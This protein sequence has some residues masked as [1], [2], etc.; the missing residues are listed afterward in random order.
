MALEPGSGALGGSPESSGRNSPIPRQWRNQLGG[1]ELQIKDK[2]YRRYASGVEKA[3]L[4]F[5][6]ALEEWADYISF[7][8]KLLKALQTRPSSITAIPH[9][10]TVAKRLSQCLNPSLPSGVHQKALEV[11]NYIFT[12]IGKDGLSCDIPLYLPGLA[13]TLSFASLSV[14][15]PFLDLLESYFLQIDPRSLRPAMKS[16][17]LALLPGLED[18]TSEDFDRTLALVASFKK[19]LRPEDSE[20][21]SAHH[22]SSDEFFWQC[23]FLASI[24]SHSRRGGALAYLVRFLPA[25]GRSPAAQDSDTTSPT[26]MHDE[27][28]KISALVTTPEPGLLVRCFASGLADD[29]LLIQRGFLDLLVSH[30]PLNSTVL[31]SRVKPADL[32]LLVKAAVGVVTRRDM[33]LNRRLWTW[34]LGPEPVS[35]DGDATGYLSTA[36]SDQQQSF[37]SSRTTYFEDFGL[38][39]LTKALLDM[40]KSSIRGNAIE[41]ARPYRI[42]LSLM[43]R[44]E[45]GG[46]IVPEVFLP[47]IESVRQF[48]DHSPSRSEFS[49]VLRSASV[50]FDGIE[51]GLIYS[52]LVSLLAQA[53][54]PGSLTSVE[55]RDKVSLVNFII[56]NFNVREEE[57]ITIH[58][59]LTCVAALAMLEDSRAR[60]TKI[61]LADGELEQLSQ[62]VLGVV[63]SLLELVP[64]RAFPDVS[65]LAAGD[66]RNEQY[67]H[68]LSNTEILK[69]I[70]AFYVHGQGNLE[71]AAIPFN[72]V[73][74]GEV[75]LHKAASFICNEATEHDSMSDLGIRV[76]ILILILLKTPTSYTFGA[77]DLLS[78]LKGKLVQGAALH[79]SYF[80]SVVQLATQLHSTDR[81]AAEQL[82]ALVAPLVS[83]AWHYLSASDPKYHVETVRC[84]WQLQTSLTLSARDIEASLSAILVDRLLLVQQTTSSAAEAARTFGVLWSHTLQDSASDRRGS[85]TQLQ[86]CRTISRLA[87]MDHYQVM[88]AQPLFLVLDALI[89]ERTQLYMVVKSWLN[90]MIG[91]DR[92]FLLFVTKISELSFV[93]SINGHE[94]GEKAATDNVVFNEN[95]DIELCLY[96]LRSL[97]HVLRCTGEMTR[98]VLASKYLYF[99][100]GEV[101]IRAGAEDNEI[102]LQEF[103]VRVCLQCVTADVADR[104]NVEL[105]ERVSQLHR[106][107][108][109]ILHEFLSSR[110]AA[111]LTSLHLDGILV[112]RLSKSIDE[113]DPYVQVLLLDVI[114]DVLKIHDMAPVE[115]ST[116]PTLEKSPPSFD[117]SRP[118]R[119]S[120]SMSESRPIAPPMPPQLLKCLQAGLS[121][122]SSHAVLDSWV[123][124]LS[125]CLPLYSQSIFQVLIP[126]V[127]TLCRQVGQVFTSLRNTFKAEQQRQSPN[128]SAPEA[129]L[130]YLLNGLEQVLALAH[131]QLLAAESRAQTVKGPEQPQSLFGSMVSG[132]FQS[133]GPQARSATANDR[134]TVHLAFQDAMRI[135]FRIWSWG[136]GEEA[137]TQ[138]QV[139][140]ASFTYTSLR[141]RNRARRLLEHLFSAETL[142]CLETVIDIWTSTESPGERALV[143]N[144]MSALDACRP[145]HSIPA[146]FNSIYSRTNPGAL[147]PSRKSTMTISLQDS[148]IVAFLVEYAR[149]LDDDAMD[150]IWQDCMTFLK[151]LLGN[152]FPHRLT[153]PGLLEFAAILGEKVDNTTF[154]EQRRMRR[155]LGDLFLRLLAALFTTRPITFSEPTHSNG[156]PDKAVRDGSYKRTT[157]GDGPE[158]VVAVLASV[159]PK[160]PKILVENDRVLAA[161]STISTNVIGPTLRSKSFPDTVSPSTMTLLR[162]L[163]RLHN[164]KK[165][166]KK[167]VG[168]AFNDPR[169]FGMRLELATDDWLPLLRQWILTDKEKMLE[170]TNRIN[171]PTTAGI[172]FGVGATSARLEADRKTQ[173]NLRRIATLILASADDTF[174]TDLGAILDKLVELMV[175]TATSS[176]S[177]TTR[178]DVFLVVRALVLKTSPV[179]LAL[180]WPVVNAEIHAAISS[181]VAPDHS[182]ASDIYV[183]TAIF[184]ACKLL[185]LLIC[186]A[187]DDF[188]L[189]E[190]LFVTDTID[191]VYPPSTY[192]P[193][194]LA[195][196]LSDELGSSVAQGSAQTDTAAHL[197]ASSAYRRPLLIPGGLGDQVSFE[198]R[199]DLIAKVLRPFFGQLSIFAFESTYAMVAVDLAGCVQDLLRDIF[200][201]R[202]MV[203]AL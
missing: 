4:L 74:S 106:Y 111:P 149:S 55:R 84:L 50:F 161:A 193:I 175:A 62:E 112:G 28:P 123:A 92:L 171:A 124:F 63:A 30:L 6:T 202:T 188:Q 72:T 103:L 121:A 115:I 75:L 191:A 35:G 20:L 177:S 166:W 150:E 59:P 138:D 56:T 13:P 58:A 79:F 185:D 47:V 194:A 157:L 130:I 176:P 100:D 120:I 105:V 44:W 5:E 155:E 11:Y 186:V 51:S 198:R 68:L 156:T 34:L 66:R 95:D 78:H 170:I 172:V 154:G 99:G 2:A 86:D 3:L 73:E 145:R 60:K 97:Q 142:E 37:L 114:Y 126:L 108:L 180:L 104:S 16:I 196:E 116:S 57:M 31:Q 89:D 158:D 40:I 26:L 96:Y 127:E 152:P 71:G 65:D 24:T 167:D 38:Q 81:I 48:Q 102:T 70:Q 85:R 141:M 107:A 45:I 117:R 174:V 90:T 25:L 15:S 41:R 80:S 76:R 36:P 182:T 129:T 46:L 168:D 119:Q 159:A 23:F 9:K 137:K 8:N 110:Y 147:E 32:E 29:Q 135:C 22:S 7:L 179:H 19:A 132:V 139:S 122:A 98:A 42:C 153:L 1:E 39:P 10:A 14:R 128:E 131:D 64:E 113:S 17:I 201:E 169:F 52:E 54:G 77:A 61:G 146:L 49:E 192:Q 162:E 94:G 118:S 148:D 134:L 87:G 199:D 203:R 140:A 21:L 67:A 82:S 173:L 163:S 33:S 88:L 93:A 69:K 197:A 178:A 189:H 43:D 195:D 133:D 83:H 53:I 91:I 165:A 144:F 164:N 187:P 12:T 109:T 184:Q 151:D 200:D 190:W 125:D 101:H 143:F 18:E 160:L 27:N 183:N 181:V 136:E